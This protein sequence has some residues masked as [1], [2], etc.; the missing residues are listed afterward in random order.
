MGSQTEA[1]P[2]TQ[3]RLQKKNAESV[4]AANSVSS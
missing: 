3:A 4:R 2:L 1:T